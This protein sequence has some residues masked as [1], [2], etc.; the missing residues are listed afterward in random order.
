MPA[1]DLTQANELGVVFCVRGLRAGA[2]LILVDHLV[3]HGAQ[4][5]IC[6]TDTNLRNAYLMRSRLAAKPAMVTDVVSVP[7]NDKIDFFS[8]G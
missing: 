2:L 6:V 8:G 3:S 5:R 1:D 4:E 7:R